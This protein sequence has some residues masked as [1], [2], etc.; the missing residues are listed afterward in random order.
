MA[1]TGS[2]FSEKNNLA[3]Q[4]E[5]EPRTFRLT[6]GTQNGLFGRVSETKTVE[7]D[8]STRPSVCSSFNRWTAWHLDQFRRAESVLKYLRFVIISRR[9]WP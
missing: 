2:Q 5:F 6:T 3:P 8:V 7:I 4:V 9:K 1:S